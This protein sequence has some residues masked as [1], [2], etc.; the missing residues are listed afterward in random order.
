MLD[1]VPGT[2]VDGVGLRT[3]IY[4]AGCVHGCEGC[5]NRR[6]WALD[7]GRDMAVDEI[8]AHIEDAGLNVT[9][10][11]GDPMLRPEG[12]TALAHMIKARTTKTIWC[13]TG[14]LYEE[15]LQHPLRRALLETIDVSVC[16]GGA[17]FVVAVSRQPQS[18]HHRCSSVVGRGESGAVSTRD[19]RH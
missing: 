8:F 9:F 11:G 10:S 3:S 2:S 1:I 17:R 15:L 7:G 5:H 16:A 14:Y 4:C 13:Y 6:S 12:F 18:T 19:L